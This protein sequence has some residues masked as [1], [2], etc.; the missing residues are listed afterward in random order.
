MDDPKAGS[1]ETKPKAAADATPKTPRQEAVENAYK[2]N[3]VKLE[4]S[5]KTVEVTELKFGDMLKHGS[6]FFGSYMKELASVAFDAEGNQLSAD[7]IDQG[8]VLEAIMI[9]MSSD[10]DATFKMI[11]VMT[12]ITP[13][14]IEKL[15]TADGAQLF[16]ACMEA[17]DPADVQRFFQM[18]AKLATTSAIS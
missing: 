12:Q 14:E 5:G 1:K 3:E 9:G 7:K 15:P 8:A 4:K 17:I 10:C 18:G 16:E 6:R 11:S 13:A 2:S